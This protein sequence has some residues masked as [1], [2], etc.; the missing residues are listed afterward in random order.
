MRVGI[1]YKFGPGATEPANL[2]TPMPVKALPMKAP[3]AAM[4]LPVAYNWTGFYVGAQAGYSWS[5]TTV[6]SSGSAVGT[7]TIGDPFGLVA[8]TAAASA[9]AVAQ[10]IKADPHGFIGGGEI[11]Y[12]WQFAP[13]WVAGIEADISGA[14]IKGS[15]T[16]SGASLAGGF[17]FTQLVTASVAAQEKV[18]WLGTVRGRLGFTPLDRFLVYGTGGLAYGHVN[19]STTVSEN[20]NSPIFGPFPTTTAA[21][22]D[23]ATRTG[24]AA[25]F[26][27]EYGLTQN[28]TVKAEWLHWDLGSLTYNTILNYTFFFG[29]QGG[30]LM[31]TSTAHFNGDIARVGI[32]YKFGG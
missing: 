19:A 4:P 15:D 25:G 1:N 2:N 17:P 23:S 8:P 20:I 30:T 14:G 16:K 18:D 6:D 12:N 29:L 24:W 7:S 32:N 26:G 9:A 28:W 31:T 13:Q 22:S 10:S 3:P 27:F 11:G 5:N 21:T